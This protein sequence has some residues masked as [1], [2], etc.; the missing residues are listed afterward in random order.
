MKEKFFYLTKPSIGGG[1]GYLIPFES[2]LEGIANEIDAMIRDGDIGE[3]LLITIMEHEREEF[4]T[5]PEF[6]GW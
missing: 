5:A 2:G 4:N 3:D 6:M 1:G